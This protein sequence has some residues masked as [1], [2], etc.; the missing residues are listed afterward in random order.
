MQLKSFVERRQITIGDPLEY[1]V[2]FVSTGSYKLLLPEKE[3]ELGQWTVKERAELP[4]KDAGGRTLKYTLAAFTTGETLIPEQVYK[5]VTDSGEQK[6]IVAPAIPVQIESILARHSNAAGMRDIKPPLR[7]KT[8]LSYYIMWL[9][10]I[11]AL[12]WTIYYWYI[13]YRLRKNMLPAAPAAPP[14]PPYDI[15]MRELE[16]LKA[17]GLIAEGRIKEY[18]IALFDIVRNFLSGTYGI[19]TRERTSGEIFQQL[20]TAAKDRKLLPALRDF[21]E[22]CDLVKFA[23][24]RPDEKIC[25]ADLE[26]AK[27]I[28]DNINATGAAVQ[29]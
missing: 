18:Y 15:A 21:F 19:D 27:N 8:P 22:E 9:V 11:A 14:E 20:R 26:T 6:E 5:Y 25:L 2:T 16:K 3:D 1:T 13:K 23:K 29:R 24:Y 12:C 28:V 7:I 10:A 4:S 17:S